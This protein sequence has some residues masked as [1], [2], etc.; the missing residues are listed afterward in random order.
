M[1]P[2]GE[3][4][5]LRMLAH[6]C[7]KEAVRRSEMPFAAQHARIKRKLASQRSSIERP[8]PCSMCKNGK[9]YSLK[10]VNRHLKAF[11]RYDALANTSSSSSSSDEGQQKPTN[12]GLDQVDEELVCCT[13][14]TTFS[15]SSHHDVNDDSISS[16][17]Q[18][19]PSTSNDDQ[20]E[21]IPSTSN[22]DLDELVHSSSPSSDNEDCR[23]NSN[24]SCSENDILGD[25]NDSDS[26]SEMDPGMD[27]SDHEEDINNLYSNANARLP[28]YH[29][30][31]VTVLQALAGYFSWFTEFPAISKSALSSILNINKNILP[32]PNNLPGS[33]VEAMKFIKP[34]LLPLVTYHVCVNDCIIYR[35]TERYDY[36]KLQVC[37]VCGASRYSSNKQPVR[38]FEYF[39]LGPR[40]KRMYG[41]ASISEVLQ[42]HIKPRN[43]VMKDVHDSPSWLYAFSENGISGSDPRAILLQLSTDG[44]N[45]FSSNKVLYSMWPIMISNINLPRYIRSFFGNIMLAGIIPAQRG[46]GE[47][48]NLDPYL[49]IVVDELLS[50]C[51]IHIYDAFNKESFSFKAALLNYV[52]DYPGCAKTF[53]AAG[54]TAL[55][56]CMWCELRGMYM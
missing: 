52:L 4:F 50:L 39:P 54:P 49:E 18:Q 55:Q 3:L 23:M 31:S 40:W 14:D 51:G 43:H 11:G 27:D 46:G 10:V 34:F 19:I 22:L 35:K 20:T 36:S 13:P 38:K 29:G 25:F 56:A 5:L 7:Q 1:I 8:C 16:D 37:P 30:S 2:I 44:V 28:L 6:T 12:L 9:S 32:C 15:T 26:S 33:F 42:S 47:P 24:D 48:K 21:N 41:N 45:P 17:D 53:N